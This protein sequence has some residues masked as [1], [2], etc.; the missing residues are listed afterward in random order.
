VVYGVLLALVVA[1]SGFVPP[2]VLPGWLQGFTSGQPVTQMIDA[3]RSILGGGAVHVS[4]AAWASLAWCAALLLVLGAL[5]MRR[6]R[7]VA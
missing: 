7:G 2:S 5:V 4:G 3:A 6:R 1:S